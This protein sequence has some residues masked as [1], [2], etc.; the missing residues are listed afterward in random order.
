MPIGVGCIAGYLYLTSAI[1]LGLVAVLLTVGGIFWT[2]PTTIYW[3]QWSN[4]SL[5]EVLGSPPMTPAQAQR[6]GFS[7]GI[8]ATAAPVSIPPK[9]E[10]RDLLRLERFFRESRFPNQASERNARTWLS[11][12][13][14]TYPFLT[15]KLP[16]SVETWLEQLKNEIGEEP[17]SRLRSEVQA[18]MANHQLEFPEVHSKEESSPGVK[19]SN[20]SDLSD[21]G[22]PRIT[23]RT[24]RDLRDSDGNVLRAGTKGLFVWFPPTTPG[25]IEL[26]SVRIGESTKTLPLDSVIAVSPPGHAEVWN[27][28]RESILGLDRPPYPPGSDRV[29]SVSREP[30]PAVGETQGTFAATP[31][32]DR[33]PEGKPPEEAVLFDDTLEIEATGHAEIHSTLKKGTRVSGFAQEVSGLPFD[34]YIMDR[35]NYVQFCEDR[36]G[37]EI[38]SDTDRVA[39]DFKKTIPRDGVWYFVFDTYGKQSDREVRFE[40]RATET[41]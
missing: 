36:G 17:H 9:E 5:L 37:S 14:V 38:Y 16:Q 34:F 22:L 29:A 6:T 31:A 19:P 27:K 3:G 2:I 33:V 24:T 30:V 11:Y 21:G 1:G 13:H 4:E 32:D 10:A 28:N 26:V 35:R 7:A 40:L 20:L 23:I 8:S 25:G 12:L 41:S 18:Y 39:L 15:A